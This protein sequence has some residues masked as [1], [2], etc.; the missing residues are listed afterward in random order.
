M[1]LLFLFCFLQVALGL[2]VNLVSFLMGFEKVLGAC[3]M[4]GVL[5]VTC[6]LA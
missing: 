6:A 1:F 2:V 4:V 5:L 3:A